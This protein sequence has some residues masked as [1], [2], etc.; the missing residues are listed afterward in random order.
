MALAIQFALVVVTCFRPLERLDSAG[1]RGGWN[2]LLAYLWLG[3]FFATGVLA[4]CGL[5]L[6]I[7]GKGTPR[8]AAG[9]WSLVVLGMFLV[10]LVFFVN[11]FH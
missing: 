8:I 5:V 11:S 3:S 10:N 6:A 7:L 4:F 2:A 1:L 9:V